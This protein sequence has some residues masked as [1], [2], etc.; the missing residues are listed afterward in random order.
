MQ[1]KDFLWGGRYGDMVGGDRGAGQGYEA[2]RGVGESK[3]NNSH[4]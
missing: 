4:K 2:R 1:L 3:S